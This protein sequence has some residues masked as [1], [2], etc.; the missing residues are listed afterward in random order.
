MRERDGQR[1]SHWW[2]ARSRPAAVA[3]TSSRSCCSCS[4]CRCSTRRS[5]PPSR[6]PTSRS[7]CSTRRCS[8]SSRSGSTS[9]SGRPGLLDLGYVGFF[10]IGAYTAALLSSPDSELGVRYPW[11][12]IVPIAMV[13]TMI[14]G[15][16][17][18][19][20]DAAAARRLPGDR[21][22]RLRRDRPAA[23]RQ[24]R[25]AARQ[26]G[27]PEHRA[28]RRHLRRRHADLH[29]DRRPRLLLARGHASSSSSC[30]SWGTSSARGSGGRGSPSARTR[31]PPS[32]SGV[33]TYRFKIWAF[34]IGA[35]VGGL[36]GTLFAAQVGLR[37]QPALRHHHVDPLPRRGGARRAGQQG[38]RDRRRV[39]RLLHPRPVPVRAARTGSWSSALALI[40]LMIF[41]PQGL[42][43]M[44]Q[45]L[46]ANGRQAYQKLFGGGAAVA[47]SGLTA[48]TQGAGRPARRR[49]R[50]TM[51]APRR[52]EVGNERAV[53]RRA[54]RV[55]TPPAEE[56]LLEALEQMD[57][58][59][60]AEHDAA[61]SAAVAP[62]REIARRD[63]RDPARGGRADRALRRADR[64]RRRLLRRPPRRDP[65]PD[66]PERRRQDD[67]LQHHDRRLPADLGRHP[68]RGQRRWRG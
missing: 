20:A 61:V 9:S 4:R 66:R 8:R 59:E 6:T 28:S 49:R 40:V 26:P 62:D 37:Q 44:R 68:P 13:V 55:E 23:R 21:H 57:A 42:L 7:R 64:A 51:R 53:V 36:S 43:G 47:P 52:G 22:A 29:P 1:V 56:G 25:P 32:S 19:D 63:G 17:P 3:A 5:S 41:R 38:R 54:R 18:R 46:L 30:C 48:S 14:S 67:L 11:L 39:P 16:H 2:N 35:A 15:R 12:V 34:A 45:H 24:R 33:P 65:R 10:A 27:L 58:A 50:T 60:R 31:T